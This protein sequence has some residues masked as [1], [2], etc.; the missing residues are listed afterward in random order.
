MDD[1][2][3]GAHIRGSRNRCQ[4]VADKIQTAHLRWDILFLQPVLKRDQIHRF[5]LIEQLHHRIKHDPVLTLIKIVRDHDLRCRDDRIPVHQ[6]GTDHRLLRL[7][8]V[9]QNPFY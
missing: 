2:G 3:I 5:S 8:A 7:N 4:D 6:H 9:R 1:R